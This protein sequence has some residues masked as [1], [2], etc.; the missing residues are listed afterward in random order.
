M[1]IPNKTWCSG[2]PTNVNYGERSQTGFKTETNINKYCHEGGMTKSAGIPTGYGFHYAWGKF[3]TS[4]GVTPNN[5]LYA[6]LAMRNGANGDGEINFSNL[7]GVKRATCAITGIGIIGV[8]G[9]VDI[10]AITKLTSN[11]VGLATVDADIAALVNMV[12]GIAGTSDVEAA[13]GGISLAVCNII[14]EASLSGD[15]SGNALLSSDIAGTSTLTVDIIASMYITATILAEA[16]LSGD[17]DAEAFM[18]ADLYVGAAADPLSPAALAA[19]LWNAVAN[20]YN[21]NGTMGQ[22]LNSAAVGGVDY[23]ALANSVWGAGDRQ[24]TAGTK[25]TEIEGILD[26]VTIIGKLTGHK[27]TKSGDII[28]IYE[29]DGVTTWRQYNLAGGGRRQL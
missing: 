16:V 13:L 23:E 6:Y 28:T 29:E 11:I 17:I 21:D 24:L 4:I 9:K 14:G 12:A 27:V 25:D 5:T 2:S 22:K 8:A 1:L 15:I 7:A 20:E 3:I 18:S 26:I 19:A 10:L